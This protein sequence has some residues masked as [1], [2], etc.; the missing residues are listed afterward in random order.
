MR[1]LQTNPIGRLVVVALLCAPLFS[2]MTGCS[3]F[4]RI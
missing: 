4:E 1:S 3:M 2:G